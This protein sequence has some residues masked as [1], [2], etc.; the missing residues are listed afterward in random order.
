MFVDL[1]CGIGGFSQAVLNSGDKVLLAVDNN[2]D[3]LRI[4]NRNISGVNTS[5]RDI[6]AEWND[7]K[8][9]IPKK[10]VIHASPQ[11]K[12][13]LSWFLFEMTRGKWLWTL[14]CDFCNDLLSVFQKGDFDFVVVKCCLHNIP[15]DSQKIIAS[16]I[17]KIKPTSN[18]KLSLSQH[19]SKVGVKPVSDFICLKNLKR[20]IQLPCF[21]IKKAQRVYWKTKNKE[22]FTLRDVFR[23]QTFP[24]SFDVCDCS[25]EMIQCAT[26][27]E[28][29]ILIISVIENHV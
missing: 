24:E 22:K 23:L 25:F 12:K 1:F 27:V 10:T 19:W 20:S 26:P 17:F 8:K 4:Y 11:S 5:C 16:N 21:E 7:I 29:G 6:L 9:Q 13:L 28:L 2:P 18:I 14:E 15:H 3:V